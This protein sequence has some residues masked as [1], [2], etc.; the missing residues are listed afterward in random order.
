MG[1]NSQKL[2]SCG[3]QTKIFSSIPEHQ[4]SQK[5]QL[6]TNTETLAINSREMT[7]SKCIQ[8]QNIA[9]TNGIKSTERPNK[10][11]TDIN[12]INWKLVYN[13]KCIMLGI[14]TLLQ[15]AAS[16]TA[17]QCIPFLGYQT[18]GS[19][20]LTTWLKI[21]ICYYLCLNSF[22]MSWSAGIISEQL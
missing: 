6:L 3:N 7:A 4:H 17:Y 1:V 5:S 15:V 18:G 20:F 10:A 2:S 11:E 19:H 9:P 21:Q 22:L 8:K 14:S 13:P 12:A 16:M